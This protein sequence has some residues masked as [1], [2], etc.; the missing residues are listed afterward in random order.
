MSVL[1][2]DAFRILSESYAKISELGIE[3]LDLGA[4]NSPAQPAKQDQ[5]IQ[6]TMLY[7]VVSDLLILNDAGTAIIGTKNQSVSKINNLLLKLKKAAGIYTLPVFATPLT[8]YQF[9]FGSNDGQFDITAGQLGDLI[10][11]NGTLFTNFNKGPDGTVL[12]STVTGL[13]WQNVVG[14]GIPSGGTIG[15]V[16]KKNSNTSY[17][18]LWDT[19][20]PTDIGVSASVAEINILD[21]AL[22]ST[23]EANTL[24]GIDTGLSIQD[25]LDAKMGTL[26]PTGSFF[27]GQLNVATAV[28]PSGDVTFNSDGLFAITALSIVDGDIATNAAIGR[29]KLASGSSNR[30]VVNNSLGVMTDAAAIAADFVLVSNSDGIPVASGVSTTQ[31]GYY[32]ISSS[33][34]ASLDERLVVSLG[35]LAQGD[36]ILYNGSDWINLALGTSGQVLTSNGTTAV[37]GNAAANGLPS[38]GTANQFLTKIDGTDYNATWSTLTLSLVT[39]VTA[40]ASEVNILD[41]ATFTTAEANTLVGMSATPIQDQLDQKLSNNLAVNAIW[42]GGGGNTAQQVSA[43]PDNSILTVI[44]GVPTWQ[45]PPTP[46]NVSGPVSSTDNAI[47]RWNGIGGNSIQDS[48][49]ILDDSNNLTFPT[50][51]AIRTNTSAG[52]TLLLQAYD[53]DGAAYVTFGTLTA[54][55]TPTF[56]LNTSTTLGTAYVYRVGGT[57]VSLAD[58]GTGVSLSDPGANTAMVW[59]NTLNQVRF[60][61]LSGLT[62]DSGTNTLTASGGG[63]GITGPGASTDNAIVRWDGVGGSAVKNSGVIIDGSNNITG[64]ANITVSTGSALRTGTSAANTLLLQAYDVDGAAYTTFAT[65]TANNTPTM[66]LSSAVT[67]GTAYIYRVGGTDISLADGGTGASLADPGAD[68]ILFWD[69]SLG[70]VTWLEVSTGL[71]LSGTTLIA[72][73]EYIQ[74]QVGGILTNTTTINFTYNDGTPSITADVNDASISDAKLR[75]SAALSVIGRSANSVGNVADIVAG[76]DYNILRR[77][78]A[79]IGFGTIDLSQS[80]AVGASVLSIT[81]GGTGSATKNFWSISGSTTITTPTLVG[82]PYFNGSVLIAPG[83]AT[84]TASTTLDVRGTATGSALAG[85]IAN[86]SNQRIIDFRDDGLI[87]IGSSSN[88]FRIQTTATGTTQS[89]SGTNLLLVAQG[90]PTSDVARVSFLETNDIT[91]T[92]GTFSLIGN[93][94]AGVVFAPTSGSATYIHFR[95]RPRINT[96]GTYGGLGIGYDWNP[97]LTSTTGFTNIAF[98]AQSG[99]LLIGGS[100]LTS[101]SVLVDFQS[102]TLGVMMPRVTNT[103]SIPTPVNGMQAYDSATNKFIFRQNG[104][105]INIGDVAGPSSSTDNT[106]ARFDLTTGKIIQSS[107][108]VVDDL[109]NITLGLSSTSGTSRIFTVNNS[110]ADCDI[111]IYGKGDGL[112][113]IGKG[114]NYLSINEENPFTGLFNLFSF[115]ATESSTSYTGGIDILVE[116]GFTN[117]IGVKGNIHGFL[118]FKAGQGDSTNNNGDD[119]AFYGGEAYSIGNGDGGNLYFSYGAGIGTGKDGNIAIG[120]TTGGIIDFKSMEK[121]MFIGNS[122]AVPIGNPSD[123]GFF[124]VESGALK[125]WGSSGTITTLGPA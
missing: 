98:R 82:N 10:V 32:D 56:D 50:A 62:Y 67:I 35:A 33:L 51:S 86:G 15:Q 72:D 111:E 1:I 114:N 120:F 125:W 44:S 85:R 65:L 23:A 75:T 73:A 39:D 109:S 59:D 6:V 66:D 18:V 40:S 123:G 31:L 112:V 46:G 105:W 20:D 21:G 47:T 78:G 117:I 97:D 77:S 102:T 89:I 113:K 9:N 28:A 55:N 122:G 116:D 16:L 119:I 90:T 24:V 27:V 110:V 92:S 12:V 81:N 14:N 58:G 118:L 71:T 2:K 101:G 80:G 64:L 63:G 70:S 19:L 108:L 83:A 48:G 22:F 69:D 107:S 5:L 30:L 42:V 41:G 88:A 87:T 76:S 61:L 54:N 13:Q 53:V 43:G 95:G 17:D 45:T 49:L 84:I 79:S 37:W 74:D 29:S 52:N 38:G 104:S 103:A 94:A 96:T 7:G 106:V 100:T 36:I 34:Q 124:Y 4:E 8:S 91:L 57:D 93:T 3:C 99:S 11:H 115:R 26:L 25:Q 60:A 121:G 68:R